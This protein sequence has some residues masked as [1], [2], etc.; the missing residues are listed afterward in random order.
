MFNNKLDTYQSINNNIA[1]QIN[2]ALKR[3]PS[4]RK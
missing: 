4:E 3:L 2:N 1:K